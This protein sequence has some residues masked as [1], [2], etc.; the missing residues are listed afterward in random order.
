MKREKSEEDLLQRIAD[1]WASVEG[2]EAGQGTPKT[3][4]SDLMP[5]INKLRDSRPAKLRGD[6]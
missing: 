1:I 6:K 4:K 5:M 3:L 2:S